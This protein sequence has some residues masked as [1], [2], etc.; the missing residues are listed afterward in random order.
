MHGSWPG[1]L[2]PPKTQNG[3]H[4]GGAPR[5]P[6]WAGCVLLNLVVEEAGPGATEIEPTGGP[7]GLFA[8]AED[9]HAVDAHGGEGHLPDEDLVGDG[10]VP[11]GY[12]T[13]GYVPVTFLRVGYD[14]VSYAPVSY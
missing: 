3:K 6:E 5:S 2:R 11:E 9:R 7:S 10:A 4:R 8:S 13:E 12:A 14:C 1:P